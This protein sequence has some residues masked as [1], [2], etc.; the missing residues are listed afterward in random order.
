VTTL[1]AGVSF[2]PGKP[3]HKVWLTMRREELQE[4]DAFD[5]GVFCRSRTWLFLSYVVSFGAVAGSV[6]VLMQVGFPSSSSAAVATV[7]LRIMNLS[8]Q[9]AVC[10]NSSA[11]QCSVL[12]AAWQHACSRLCLA[13]IAG[14]VI[15]TDGLR[16]LQDYALNTQV[17]D[18]W[19]GVAGLF[20]VS[21]AMI[22]PL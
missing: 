4:F 17:E 1:S 5:E 19:P 22:C 11:V 13:T 20:Q 18:T 14:Q 16:V 6:W 3:A 12:Y 21:V 9:R 8:Q 10:R 15:I 2:V 7:A